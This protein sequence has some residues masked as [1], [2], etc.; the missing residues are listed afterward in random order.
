MAPL[1]VVEQRRN[2][3]SEEEGEWM[4][5]KSIL[6]LLGFIDTGVVLRAKEKRETQ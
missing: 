3:Y 2:K 1:R 6:V 5:Q 4:L